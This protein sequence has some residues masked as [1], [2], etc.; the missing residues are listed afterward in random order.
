MQKFKSEQDLE[1][2]NQ[3][4]EMGIYKRKTLR[5]KERK[6]AFD[7]DKSKIQEKKKENMLSIKNKERKQD[8]DHEKRK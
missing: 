4:A 5:I 6:H 3:T 7:E 1:V 2:R 8:L